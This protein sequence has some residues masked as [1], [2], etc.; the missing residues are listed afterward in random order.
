MS[1]GIADII[2]WRD[3]EF[4]R[5][6]AVVEAGEAPIDWLVPEYRVTFTECLAKAEELGVD[7]DAID[8]RLALGTN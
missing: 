7:I 3:S 4:S 2:A 8:L 1:A 5:R 6:T